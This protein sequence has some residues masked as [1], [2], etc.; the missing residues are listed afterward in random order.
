MTTMPTLFVSHGAPS[1]VIEDNEAHHFLKSLAGYI[2]KPSAIIINSAHHETAGVSVVRDPNPGMIYDFSGFDDVLRQMVYA[3]PGH[4]QLADRVLGTLDDAGFAPRAVQER[5]YDHGAWNPLMLAF[6]EADIPVVQL[7]IDPNADAAWHMK[8][9]RALTPLRADGVLIVGSGH[10]TH[11][12]KALFSIMRGGDA[13]PAL[14]G[15][16]IAFTDWMHDA[17]QSG[18]EP[19]LAAWLEKA[20]HARANHPT[21]EH[22]FPIFTAFGAAGEGARGERIHQSVEMDGVFAWDAYRFN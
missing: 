6:P 11:N 5:G 18:D 15:K 10:I 3:A 20:P 22:L 17:L 4:P 14:P 21:D 19:S 2:P 9:G 8:L 1:I 7:S 13:D 12:L 16:V